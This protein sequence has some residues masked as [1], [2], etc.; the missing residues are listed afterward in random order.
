VKKTGN[1]YSIVRECDNKI[2]ATSDLF[3]KYKGQIIRTMY[4]GERYGTGE[5]ILEDEN[6]KRIYTFAS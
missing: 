4:T 2:L 5:Y 3:E 1:S 6:G